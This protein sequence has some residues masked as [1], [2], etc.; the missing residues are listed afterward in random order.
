MA[1]LSF[2]V[3]VHVTEPCG[4]KRTTRGGSALS[5]HHKDQHLRSSGSGAGASAHRAI[6]PAL[7]NS[8]VMSVFL[9]F[10]E[11]GV[12]VMSELL[13]P[14][15]KDISLALLWLTFTEDQGTGEVL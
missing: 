7:M 13:R 3:C 4:S 11:G 5:F 10:M 2:S 1:L 15:W 14:P 12:L 8:L 9:G 6:P